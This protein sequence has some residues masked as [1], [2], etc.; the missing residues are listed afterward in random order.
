MRLAFEVAIPRITRSETM[1]ITLIILHIF[2]IL[3]PAIEQHPHSFPLHN[4]FK[5]ETDRSAVV[6]ILC[7][8]LRL[9]LYHS[10]CM[11]VVW[12][13]QRSWVDLV[14]TGGL[15]LLVEFVQITTSFVR[16]AI[17]TDHVDEKVVVFMIIYYGLLLTTMAMTL[18]FAEK[19]CQR[20]ESVP[21]ELVVYAGHDQFHDESVRPVAL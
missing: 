7:D 13:S 19:L 20:R 8:V 21:M 15:L 1:R 17:E 6:G 2:L 18:R 14:R 3:F 4:P 16:Y 9:C 5:H 10:A 11:L 12:F